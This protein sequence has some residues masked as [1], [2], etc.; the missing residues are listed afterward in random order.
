MQEVAQEQGDEV[1]KH[2]VKRIKKKINDFIL[3]GYHELFAAPPSGSPV[4]GAPVEF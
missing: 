3:N 2:S 4:K 1:Y